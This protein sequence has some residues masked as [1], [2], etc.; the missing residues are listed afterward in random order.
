MRTLLAAT[1]LISASTSFFGQDGSVVHRF[2]Y[3]QKAPLDI[4]EVGI[5]H[6]G[7]IEILD[8]SYASPKGGRVPAYL[9]VPKG[10]GPFAG[11]IWGHW[12]WENSA[13]RNRKEFLD[14]AVVLA[15]N[16]VMSLQ[17]T[18]QSRAPAM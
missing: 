14:E 16:G 8:I 5:E 4:K 18:V 7:D 15:G 6:R 9:V 17:P 2:D 3:G 13:F 1:M 11:V 10:K 12:Y